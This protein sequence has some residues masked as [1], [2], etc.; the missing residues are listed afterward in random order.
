MKTMQKT[1][2]FFVYSMLAMVCL[3]TACSDDD[4]DS[5]RIVQYALPEKMQLDVA[6]VQPVIVKSEAEFNALFGAYAAQ[7]TKV[8]FTKYDL[9]YGQG[10]SD[11]GV[12]SFE[13]WIDGDTP[14]YRLVVH[15][16]Q[17]YTHEYVRWAVAY[18][19]PKND[20][21]QVTMAVSVE[22]AE[23]TASNE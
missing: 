23:G 21:N 8:D 7:L 4:D 22:M 16:E 2:S 12:V 18:L 15:I 11:Y 9:V 5:V 17:N 20:N 19:L 1:I 3:F 6:D 13:S 10:A 14:P